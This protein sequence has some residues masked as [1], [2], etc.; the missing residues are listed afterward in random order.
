MKK[1]TTFVVLAFLV[2]SLTGC[3]HKDCVSKEKYKKLQEDTAIEIANLN[4][5]IEAI[6]NESADYE[7]QAFVLQGMLNSYKSSQTLHEETVKELQE[8]NT[9]LR[10][11][12]AKRDAEIAALKKT[13]TSTVAVPVQVY[14]LDITQSELLLSLMFNPD[15]DGKKYED[16]KAIWY[17]N[18]YCYEQVKLTGSIQLI[19]DTVVEWELPN[20]CT[21]Y[22]CRTTNNAFVHS[23]KKP[24][25]TEIK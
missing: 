19:C 20:G 23:M 2:L 7:A 25:L 17:S 11:E 3:S 8:E 9:D 12:L 16:K 21:V 6:K 18:P 15:P 22:T 1:L 10:D 5:E 14:P 13:G 4:E 24:H